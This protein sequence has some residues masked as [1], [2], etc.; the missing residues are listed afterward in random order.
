MLTITFAIICH[1]QARNWRTASLR[2]FPQSLQDFQLA[3][4]LFW[5]ENS[6]LFPPG[7]T[8][9]HHLWSTGSLTIARHKLWSK[10]ACLGL[11]TSLSTFHHGC[12]TLQVLSA[13]LCPSFSPAASFP[14]LHQNLNNT[15][16][17]FHTFEL[18]EALTHLS[19]PLDFD[20][21]TTLGNRSS[22]P[23][24]TRKMRLWEVVSCSSSY[25]LPFLCLFSLNSFQSLTD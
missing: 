18:H 1:L 4:Q 19:S 15:Q 10:R 20:L 7:S 11:L 2:N 13:S 23:L 24:C 5:H 3:G 8:T 22:F 17:L 16:P 9:F 6:M 12:S 21:Q 14:L 25:R